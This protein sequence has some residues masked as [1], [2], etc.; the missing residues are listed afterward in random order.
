MTQQ[1]VQMLDCRHDENG[2]VSLLDG[3][4]GVL[5]KGAPLVWLTFTRSDIGRATNSAGEV[6]RPNID[7]QSFAGVG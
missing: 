1:A 7:E 3:H 2:V 6:F 5:P 4:G